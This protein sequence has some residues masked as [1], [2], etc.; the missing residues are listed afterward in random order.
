MVKVFA[1]EKG[2][3]FNEIFSPVVKMTSIKT[4]LSLVA[5]KDFHLQQLDVK[6]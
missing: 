1:K 5:I 3:N 2:I 6:I 4:I